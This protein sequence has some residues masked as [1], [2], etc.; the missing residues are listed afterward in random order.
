MVTGDL[1]LQAM[2]GYRQIMVIGNIWL[3]T[4]TIGNSFLQ[5]TRVTIHSYRHSVVTG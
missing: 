3:Q 5:V 2:N 4:N 1:W